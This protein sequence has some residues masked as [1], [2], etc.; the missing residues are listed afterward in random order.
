MRKREH[1]TKTRGNWGGRASFFPPGIFPFSQITRSYFHAPFNHASSILSDNEEDFSWVYQS[2][3][4]KSMAMVVQFFFEGG[5]GG[6]GGCIEGVLWAMR[7]WLIHIGKGLPNFVNVRWLWRISRAGDLG[8]SETEKYFE[9]PNKQLLDEVF[10]ISPI[11]KVEVSVFS[12]AEGRV[13]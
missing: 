10:L 13:W 5:G 8:Y 3:Q 4:E 2:S 11:I 1:K 12:R 7:K 6:G 9:W